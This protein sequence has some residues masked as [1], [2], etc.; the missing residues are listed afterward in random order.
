MHNKLQLSYPQ[1]SSERDR[2]EPPGVDFTNNVFNS[3]IQDLVNIDV[4]VKSKHRLCGRQYAKMQLFHV[5][6]R[7]A[8]P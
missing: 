6:K 4:K 7:G 8:R 3:G 5:H 1:R 2:P